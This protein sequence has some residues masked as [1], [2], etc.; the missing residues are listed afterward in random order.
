ME[1]TSLQDQ[2]NLLKREIFR[3]EKIYQ[4]ERD[5]VKSV[6]ANQ[7]L[8]QLKRQLK[9]LIEKRNKGGDFE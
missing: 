4:N 5:S 6:F 9:L 3:Y 8:N 7:I 2:I 1:T